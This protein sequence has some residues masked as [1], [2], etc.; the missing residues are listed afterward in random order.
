MLPDIRTYNK[1]LAMKSVQ[2]RYKNRSRP[3][4]K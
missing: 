2:H 1:D 3:T 4:E